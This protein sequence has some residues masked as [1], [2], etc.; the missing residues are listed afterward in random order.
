MAYDRRLVSWT[1]KT[2]LLNLRRVFPEHTEPWL[3]VHTEIQAVVGT[4]H[5]VRHSRSL[6]RV[7]ANREDDT[8]HRDS[9]YLRLNVFQK[10]GDALV[11]GNIVFRAEGD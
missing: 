7:D 4:Q 2:D 6:A 3:E 1:M 11:D 5:S 9:V 10:L 8:I